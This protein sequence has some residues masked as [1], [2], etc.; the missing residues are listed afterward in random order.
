[1]FL[2]EP[3][4]QLVDLLELHSLMHK[5]LGFIPLGRELDLR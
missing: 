2:V 3:I 1:L 4:L 5:E